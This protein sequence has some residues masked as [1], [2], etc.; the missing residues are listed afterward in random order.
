MFFKHYFQFSQNSVVNTISSN[1]KISSLL[2]RLW[3]YYK[4]I[5]YF[6]LTIIEDYALIHKEVLKFTL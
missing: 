6:E 3:K 1:K 2:R 5:K 4:M